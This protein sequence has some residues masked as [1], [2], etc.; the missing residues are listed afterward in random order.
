MILPTQIRSLSLLWAECGVG[1]LFL[2][3]SISDL[4]VVSIPYLCYSDIIL[5]YSDFLLVNPLLFIFTIRANNPLFQ[6]FLLKLLGGFFLLIG[7][8]GIQMILFLFFSQLL[9]FIYFLKFLLLFKYSCMPFL[10]TPAKPT[11]L[12][13]L[14]PP[15]WF[16]P[17]GLYSS[18]CNPLSSQR[19][20][21]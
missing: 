4:G 18:S 11:S 9:F 3:C 19:H 20:W 1:I 10:P 5:K 15:P 17:C 14:H 12:P 21:S 2:R 16:C 13:H 7:P 6:N 8:R